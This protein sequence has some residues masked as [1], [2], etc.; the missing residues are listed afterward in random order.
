[1][2]N[3]N[4][5]A[6]TQEFIKL[7]ADMKQPSYFRDTNRFLKLIKP[8]KIKDPGFLLL[9]KWYDMS[10][11]ITEEMKKKFGGE[12]IFGGFAEK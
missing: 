6:D 8:W 2:D 5:A 11:T 7:Y 1:M 12:G 4:P 3:P 9:E 10:P